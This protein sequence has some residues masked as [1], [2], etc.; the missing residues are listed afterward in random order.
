MLWHHEMRSMWRWRPVKGPR[1]VD[2]RWLLL[3]L[4]LLLIWHY[5]NSREVPR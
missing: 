4:L 2:T 1:L 3:L 5:W